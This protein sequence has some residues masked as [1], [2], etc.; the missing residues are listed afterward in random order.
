MH[1]GRPVSQC[2]IRAISTHFCESLEKP[3]PLRVFYEDDN[4]LITPNAKV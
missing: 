2:L 3:R 4:M 1:T